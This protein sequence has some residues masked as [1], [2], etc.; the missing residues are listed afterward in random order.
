MFL[1]K[2]VIN[3]L[4]RARGDAL[5]IYLY[6]RLDDKLAERRKTRKVLVTVEELYCVP[7]SRSPDIANDINRGK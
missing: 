2:R 4:E 7:Y 1:E 5:I 3:R 6:R